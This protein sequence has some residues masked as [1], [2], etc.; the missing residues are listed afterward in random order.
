MLD[1]SHRKDL[2]V[3]FEVKL[4][5]SDPNSLTTSHNVRKLD[6]NNIEQVLTYV[7]SFD[8]IV[9]KPGMPE[10]I[11]RWNLFKAMLLGSPKQ[12]WINHRNMVTLQNRNQANFKKTLEKWLLDFMPMDVSESILNWL[13][14][15]QKPKD[16]QVMVFAAKFEHFNSLVK[17]CP[18]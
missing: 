15:L 7:R 1:D 10:G 16:M 11:Q 3:S 14:N 4:D 6:T 9:E 17:Y 18:E 5:P 8:D 2:Y 13:R 12:K